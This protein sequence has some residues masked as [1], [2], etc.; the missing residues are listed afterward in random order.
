MSDRTILVL[1]VF[2]ILLGASALGLDAAALFTQAAEVA[3]V[4]EDLAP[5][6]VPAPEPEEPAEAGDD[7][8][9]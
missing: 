6:A 9:E 3:E 5:E 4:V 2:A 7:A 1:V 8:G